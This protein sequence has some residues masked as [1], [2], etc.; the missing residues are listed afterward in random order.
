MTRPRESNSSLIAPTDCL[1]AA[2]AYQPVISTL[3]F[4]RPEPERSQR[5]SLAFPT[6]PGVLRSMKNQGTS[7]SGASCFIRVVQVG[8]REPLDRT[9]E[10]MQTIYDTAQIWTVGSSMSKAFRVLV[11][12]IPDCKPVRQTTES[13]CHG[14]RW[15][16][17]VFPCFPLPS[18]A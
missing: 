6:T 11:W 3:M 18:F 5:I 10:Y 14:M 12:R 4:E 1:K 9:E 17:L 13:A 16:S 7:R 2:E 8:Q 15:L